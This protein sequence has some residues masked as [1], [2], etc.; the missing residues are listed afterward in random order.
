VKENCPYCYLLG[1]IFDFFLFITSEKVM[2]QQAIQMKSESM[3]TNKI[4]KKEGRRRT[5]EQK[6]LN[7]SNSPVV[8]LCKLKE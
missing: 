5:K 8:P 6:I 7:T 1:R 3:C 4:G 2:Q